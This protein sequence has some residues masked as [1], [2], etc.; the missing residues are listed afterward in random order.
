MLTR[1]HQAHSARQ[2]PQESAAAAKGPASMGRHV[3][4]SDHDEGQRRAGCAGNADEP[5]RGDGNEAGGEHG[6][7]SD[8]ACQ[9]EQRTCD[10]IGQRRQQRQ[11]GEERR[12]I[13]LGRQ[14]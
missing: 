11:L 13:G 7:E 5:R 1:G 6:D 14:G 10:Q 2:S 4:E 8:K 12:R 3:P 9:G